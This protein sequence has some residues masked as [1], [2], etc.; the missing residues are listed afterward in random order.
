M[1]S[2]SA[3][4]ERLA[5]LAS[6][7]QALAPREKLMVGVGGGV[8]ALYVLFALLVQP[9]WR[10][11]RA[12]PQQLETLDGEL[13]AMQRLAVEARELHNLPP[14]NPDQAQAALRA[15]SERLGD[16]GRLA[17]QGDRAVLT[18]N[19]IGTGALRSWLA[20]VRSGARARPLEASLTRG[21]VGYSGTIIVALGA[22]A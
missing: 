21:T 16:K 3:W 18:V 9:A 5:P 1:S 7:W 11:L 2:S 20:E 14:V 19:N 10:T 22:G 6:R 12:A 15:A 13:Q 8:V 4:S 17:L